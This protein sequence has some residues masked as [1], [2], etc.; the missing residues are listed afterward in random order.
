[1][2]KSKLL[3]LLQK[4][5]NSEW[6]S[7]GQFVRSPYFNRNEAVALLFEW[8][9]AQGAAL[10]TMSRKESW[11][12][13]FPGK[14]YDE[15]MI[16]LLMS[17]LLKLAEQFIGMER[18]LDEK[19]TLEYHTLQSLYD[20]NLEKHYH[21]LYDRAQVA[22]KARSVA[23]VGH[24]YAGYRLEN[25]EAERFSQWAPRK[26]NEAAQQ[27]VNQ[28]DDF[29][30]AEKL[31][32]TAYMLTMQMVIATPHNLQLVEEVCRFVEKNLDNISAPPIRAYYHIVNLFS[33][34][35]AAADFAALKA[36]LHDRRDAFNE[37]TLAEIYQYAINF[38][39]LQLL[40]MRT[41][42]LG[43][44]LAL[45][46]DGVDSGMLLE[47]GQLSPW[48]FKNMVK[49]AL[50]LERYAWAEAFILEKSVL[51]DEGYRSDA[52]HY[53]LAELYYY[54]NRFDHAMQHLNKMEFTDIS[55]NLGAKRML[56]KIYYERNELNALDSLLH[57]HKTYLHRNK[58]ISEDLRRAHLNFIRLL[59]KILRV[60][61][62]GHPALR[63]EIEKAVLLTEKD[64]LLKITA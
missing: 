38:C 47:K 44:A 26:Y 52:L 2:R 3:G 59:G 51:L 29:Y 18:L 39:N 49:L 53:N 25:L 55:Y 4:F 63:Q 35:S 9:V 56:C 23:D 31:R 28:L 60:T 19:Q 54:T 17:A 24:F 62:S 1:M 45:Y 15:T 37:A 12:V 13:I 11:A 41:E 32:L 46:I 8:M 10:D 27:A 40:K 22:I 30:L 34:E 61:P 6:K 36:L 16:N 21:Y 20:R 48:H 5:S 50:R 43:E 33:R 42:Y 58:L 57:A 64:W 7:F 14:P